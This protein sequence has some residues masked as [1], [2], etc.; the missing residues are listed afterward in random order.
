MNSQIHPTRP[1]MPTR[2]REWPAQ[3]CKHFQQETKD[4][5]ASFSCCWR[6]GHFAEA[7]SIGKSFPVQS[8]DGGKKK[9]SA[10]NV[11]NVNQSRHRLL[12]WFC[13]FSEIYHNT[14]KK[15]ASL[16]LTFISSVA[17]VLFPTFTTGAIDCV[18]SCT[19][20]LRGAFYITNHLVAFS[21]FRRKKDF[22][23]PSAATFYKLPRWIRKSSVVSLFRR[24]HWELLC[25]VLCVPPSC[26]TYLAF[27]PFGFLCICKK[28]KVI[29]RIQRHF[30]SVSVSIWMTD[31]LS[32][33]VSGQCQW[34][35]GGDAVQMQWIVIERSCSAKKLQYHSIWLKPIKFRMRDKTLPNKHRSVCYLVKHIPEQHIIAQEYWAMTPD[36]CH[37]APLTEIFLLEVQHFVTFR[38]TLARK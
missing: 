2:Q 4:L 35:G 12:W 3:Q 15:I 29:F 14:R 5:P 9:A 22:Q 19:A 34:G 24:K 28:N 36:N 18:L 6:E 7:K 32:F 17:P 37:R 20:E 30:T 25:S 27:V 11:V 26:E 1:E 33:Q 13:D 10:Y 23:S 31:I 38:F 16:R 8:S 21:L